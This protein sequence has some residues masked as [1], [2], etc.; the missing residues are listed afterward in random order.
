MQKTQRPTRDTIAE[1][2]RPK[3]EK[4][5]RVEKCRIELSLPS[6][7]Y[8]ADVWPADKLSTDGLF[9]AIVECVETLRRDV[10][11][12]PNFQLHQIKGD[13]ANLGSHASSGC[14]TTY[15]VSPD[16]TWF[17]Q[18]RY[19]RQ[20]W[21]I[22]GKLSQLAVLLRDDP[23]LGYPA[24]DQCADGSAHSAGL[25]SAS[26]SRSGSQAQRRRLR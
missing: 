3:P 19:Y 15:C 10:K 23:S 1:L 2:P 9:D 13:L 25:A 22:E 4:I 12:R 5:P 17:A 14:F 6:G 11:G 26:P 21:M 18:Q 8:Q 24:K 16:P 7:S 20:A